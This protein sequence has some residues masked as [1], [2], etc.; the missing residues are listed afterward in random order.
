[1][2]GKFEIYKD[3]GGQFRWRLKAGNGEVV[4]SGESYVSKA[5]AKH[6]VQAVQNAAAGAQV[7]DLTE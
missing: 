7:V 1:M 4:A 3:R 2:A 5:G 6:G